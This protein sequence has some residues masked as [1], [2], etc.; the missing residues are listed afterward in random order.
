M[1]P[2]SEG[3]DGQE[4]G[5]LMVLRRGRQGLGCW[6]WGGWMRTPHSTCFPFLMFLGG[7]AYVPAPE[8]GQLCLSVQMHPRS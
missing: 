5:S 1:C 3:G 4:A 2:V 7:R 8:K 6:D